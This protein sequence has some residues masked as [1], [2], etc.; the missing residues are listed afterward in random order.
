M[1]LTRIESEMKYFVFLKEIIK[2][3]I[4]KKYYK[5]ALGVVWTVLHPLLHMLTIT[6][7]FSTLFHRSIENFPVYMLCGQLTFHFISGSGSRGLTAIIGNS[8]FLRSIYVP[9]YIFVVS[10]VTEAFVDL[11]FSLIALFPVMFVTGAPFTWNLL[12]LPVLFILEFMFA[13]GLALV[14]ATYGTFLRDLQHLYGIFTTLWHWVCALFYPITIVPSTYRFL[15][16]LNPAYHYITIMRAICYEGVPPTDK[17]LIIATCFSVL[18]LA[19][20][21]SVFR[22]NENK[23]YLYV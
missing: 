12:M 22:A 15:F 5:S 3:D 16:D 19:M 8:A 20:G 4:K 11:M 17:S 1:Q 7:V 2:R 14:L 23:F 21:I 13:L 9:K 10:R 6:I 18:M